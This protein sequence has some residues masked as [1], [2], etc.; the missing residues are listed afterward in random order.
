MTILP[1]IIASA[2]VLPSDRLAMADRLFD[3]GEYVSAKKEYDALK[4]ATGIAADE[5]LYRLAECNRLVGETAAAR[6]AYTELV[7]KFPLSRH[8]DRSRLMR[9]LTLEG[10]AKLSEL[11][12]LDSDKVRVAVRACALYHIGIATNDKDAFKRCVTL[13]PKG[14]YSLYAK[15]H[16]AS[17]TADDPNPTVRRSAIGEFLEIHHSNDPK[18]AREA[19]YFA[20][21][22][23]YSDKRYLESST[24]FR[25]YLKVYPNDSRSEAVRYHA[26]WSDYLAGRYA[27]AAA[28]CGEGK[29]DDA[30]YLL[31][32]CAFATGDHAAS[33]KLMAQYLEKFPNGK[34]RSSVEL[35]LARMDFDEAE[36][37]GDMPKM[38][39]AARRSVALSNSSHDRLRLAWAY[40]KSSRDAEAR[41][42]YDS[43][44]KAFPGTN[45]AAEALFRKAMIDIRA[46]KFSPAE[47]ALAEMLSSTKNSARK[48]EALYWRGIAAVRLGHEQKGV[49]YLKEAL[50]LGLSLDS[51]RE[52]RLIIAD[53]DFKLGR[54]KEARTSYITLVNE[55]AVER[56]GAAK[57]SAVG[58]FL[59]EDF[60]GVKATE[61]A[62]KC[63]KALLKVAGES[64][65]W[66]QESFALLGAAEEASGEFTAAIGSYR[67]ALAE[68]VNTLVRK[69]VALN[70]GVL[71]CKAGETAEAEIAL[72]EAVKLN[73]NDSLARAKAY[74]Y[75]AKNCVAAQDNQ[76]ARDYAT[77]VTTLFSDPEI[78]SEAKKI[79]DSTSDGVK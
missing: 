47:L 20:A 76:G 61:E 34:Y 21:A 72:K 43:L 68:N 66:R 3:R 48:P 75:L 57:L 59:L 25:R 11:K 65:E 32:A 29:S 7:D 30:A 27:D 45:D 63:A 70:L 60:D 44:S 46:G 54:V 73:A 50:K 16:H 79:L 55:G 74:L 67:Q 22:R 78:V 26:A 41:A 42:E 58:R 17:L 51:S 33:R 10:N 69:S 1:L 52:A 19:L 12:I 36:K 71:L 62:K 37:L 64:K 31:A 5:L 9:A 38:V 13:E 15:F 40:E 6:A 24:L 28:L 56:M 35:P 23:S 49:E 77:V 53:E 2:A 18:L 4:G 14:P 39:E 8:A